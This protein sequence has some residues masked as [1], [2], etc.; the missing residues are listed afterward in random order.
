MSTGEHAEAGSPGVAEP[1]DAE[2]PVFSEV[3]PS[4]RYGR[5]GGRA[6]LRQGGPRTA[7]RQPSCCT[8]RGGR[9]AGP[10]N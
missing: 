9:P 5:V 4:G 6:Q 3:D 7:G 2:G 8:A 1:P 10:P